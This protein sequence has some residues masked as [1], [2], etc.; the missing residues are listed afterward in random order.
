MDYRGHCNAN[1]PN[2]YQDILMPLLNSDDT[3]PL[4]MYL[5]GKSLLKLDN[6]C[7]CGAGPGRSTLTRKSKLSDQ[8]I[9]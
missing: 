3:K 9:W 1:I 6:D 7:I 4:I 2:Y 8:Y 5:I